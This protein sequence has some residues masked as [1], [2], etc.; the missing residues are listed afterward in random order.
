MSAPDP[1]KLDAAQVL[2]HAFDDATGT[3]RTTSTGTIVTPPALEVNID[4]STGDNIAISDGTDTLEINSDGS[5]N[6]AVTGE[7]TL[8]E[9]QRIKILSAADLSEAYTYAD[10]G[11]SNERITLIVYNAPSVS[12][13]DEVHKTFN[14]TL[15][16]TKYRLDSVDWSI[17]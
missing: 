13:V 5:I 2:Q 10:F 7:V 8:N 1:S 9:T 17:F 16:G 3:L 14:Y 4:A 11:T 12:L 6:T 15:V